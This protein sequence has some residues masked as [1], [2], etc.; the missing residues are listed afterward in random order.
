MSNTAK[1][2]AK[3]KEVILDVLVDQP[4]LGLTEIS[5]AIGK[6]PSSVYTGITELIKDGIVSK[7]VQYKPLA[8]GVLSNKLSTGYYVE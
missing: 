6:S 2:S 8:S 3:T 5:Q 1:V 7:G 4:G